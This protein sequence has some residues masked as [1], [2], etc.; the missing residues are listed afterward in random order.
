MLYSMETVLSVGASKLLLALSTITIQRSGL[1]G[2]IIRLHIRVRI[3]YF[4]PILLRFEN[5]CVISS[6][7]VRSVDSS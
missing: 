3:F 7:R 1:Q 5:I 4:L 2:T 6:I